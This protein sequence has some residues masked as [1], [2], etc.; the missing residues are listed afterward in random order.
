MLKASEILVRINDS[1]SFGIRSARFLAPH[2]NATWAKGPELGIFKQRDCSIELR[3]G[4]RARTDDPI[5]D[6]KRAQP[7]EL[8]HW[9]TGVQNGEIPLGVHIDQRLRRHHSGERAKGRDAGGR[10]VPPP[11]S[12]SGRRHNGRVTQSGSRRSAVRAVVVDW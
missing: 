6:L 10:L 11:Y 7:K 4:Y 5:P 1:N 12:R 9:M 3:G 8:S 2:G